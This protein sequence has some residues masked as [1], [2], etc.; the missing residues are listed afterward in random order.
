MLKLQ[1]MPNAKIAPSAI[2]K[3]KTKSNRFQSQRRNE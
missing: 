1:N 2:L 3:S